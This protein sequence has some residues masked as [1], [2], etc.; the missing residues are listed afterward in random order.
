MYLL[1][2]VVQ[3][4]VALAF[5]SRSSSAAFGLPLDDG[6]IHLVYSRSMAHL[7]GFAYNPGAQECGVTSPLWVILETPLHWLAPLWGGQV[8]YGV[9][10]VG[11]A[12][13]WLS[14]I[15]AFHLVRRLTDSRAAAW[16]SA[17]LI[18][19]DP[20]LA[21]GRVSGMEVSLAI[22]L[23]LL[24]AWCLAERRCTG[25]VVALALCPLVRPEHLLLLPMGYCCL[26]A[27]L[28]SRRS[29][30]RDWV[31]ALAPPLLLNGLWMVFCLSVSGQAFPNTYYVKHAS[32]GLL[33]LT[34]L[35]QLV[36]VTIQPAWMIRG[37][38]ALLVA[39]GAAALFM[40]MR[41]KPFELADLMLRI[42]VTGYPIVFL[43]GVA[44]IHDISQATPFYWSRYAQPGVALLAVVAGASARWIRATI[45]GGGI[46]ALIVVA[47]TLVVVRL[48]AA[49]T[50]YS[51]NCD[52][53]EELNVTLGLWLAQNARPGELIALDDAGAIRYFSE[54]PALDLIGLNS[55]RVLKDGRAAAFIAARP[56]WVV[57]HASLFPNVAT[58]PR[59][60]RVYSAKVQRYTICDCANDELV[61]YEVRSAGPE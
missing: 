61:V 34:T 60:R 10:L 26:I 30:A 50:T 16:G 52:N 22:A 40:R 17:L 27:V 48:P 44:A 54:R 47:L 11:V 59:F 28:R 7:D 5:V 9:K 12:L 29:R 1:L 13:G 56:R 57:V 15:A 53:I 35:D 8:V 45:V 2:A 19:I 24:F 14:S 4:G 51:D 38:G 31:C 20:M 46:A 25:A 55:W 41:G 58:D 18:A 43:L 49:M 3:I 32:H 23:P 37:G 6:W 33:S 21:F 36:A 42:V 39:A